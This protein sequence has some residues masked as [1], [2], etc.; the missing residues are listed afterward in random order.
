MVTHRISFFPMRKRHYSVL[1]FEKEQ[2]A[3]KSTLLQMPCLLRNVKPG[4]AKICP[5][6]IWTTVENM[7]KTSPPL[8][9]WASNVECMRITILLNQG[10]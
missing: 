1:Y 10:L 6:A 4:L 7:T 3:T 5:I 9:F 2:S 8:N